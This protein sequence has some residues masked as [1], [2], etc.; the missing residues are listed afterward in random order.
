MRWVTERTMPT[1]HF[2]N[3]DYSDSLSRK[4]VEQLKAC[5]DGSPLCE[6]D[7]QITEGTFDHAITM[8]ENDVY[9]LVM[10]KI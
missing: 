2:L 4:Q 6:F 10:N 7:I 9:M 3:M 1:L 5:S 8:N